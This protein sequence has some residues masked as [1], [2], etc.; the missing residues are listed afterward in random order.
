M[1]R[2]R[3]RVSAATA[4]LA[5]AS[6]TVVPLSPAALAVPALAAAPAP[7]DLPTTMTAGALPT[8]QTD[9]IVLSVAIV[10]NTVYAGGKFT[11]A[12]PAGV[13]A[14]G[15]GEVT[16]NNL[17]AFDLTTG[18][19]L[20]WAPV[21]TGTPYSGSD[22]GPYCKASGSQWVCDTVFRIKASPDGKKIYAGGD[23]TK[24]DG[25]WRTRV[26]RFDTA[27]GALDS[28]FA[29]SLNSRVRAI[30]VTADAVYLGGGFTTVNGSTR[31][32][33]AALDAA[34]ALTPWAPTADREVFALL[35]APAQGRVVVGGAFDRINGD[36]RPS[37]TAVEL[38]TGANAPWQVR[39]PGSETVTDIAGDGKGAAYFGAYDYAG[40]DV[41][42]EGRGS[43]DIATGATRWFD[44]CYGDTQAVTVSNGV[45]YA[46]S[47]THDCSAIGAAP[48]NGPIDYYRL[49][50]ETADAVR[51]AP[52]TVNTVRRGDP[53]PE[54]LT[55]FPNTNGG[56]ADSSF[57]NGPWAI[58]ANS[59]Y[60]VV[61]GE[62]TVVNGKP[63]QSLTR[64][65]A[66]GVPGAV[67]NG[68]QVPFRAPTVS[69]E[70]GVT[71]SPVI[72]WTGTWDA[73]N[74]ELRYEVMRL[75]TAEPIY[76]ETKA[77]RPWSVPSFSYVD[78]GAT[79]GTYWIRAVDA[80]G[81][82][83]GSPQAGI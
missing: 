78:R 74:P 29:P 71:G 14:G 41:R 49:T 40:G 31:T 30:S 12:R 17:M 42:F 11:K 60:V 53:I 48:D 54:L 5:A 63:Q 34:G 20:P 58:D 66:R 32:R 67:H 27:T 26:A 46:A 44:G 18:E 68:P 55:W 75:G 24:I 73:Q 79:S 15:A 3:R 47:H 77:S 35:A 64:F 1:S 4:V 72:K 81:A 51:S 56:P 10:G 33:L 22:P 25:K 59:Q 36:T 37:L 8:P 16:R 82:S 62:F 50:A 7:Q 76:T 23:F 19:L 83:I 57:K 80:D 52:A 13:A 9:G 21:V 69:R 2:A 28:D 6:L 45:V 61:G 70:F 65:A 39:T 43:A 38:A